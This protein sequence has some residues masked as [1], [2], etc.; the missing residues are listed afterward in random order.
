MRSGA[1]LTAESVLAGFGS[2]S[3]IIAAIAER[4]LNRKF[5]F[6]KQIQERTSYGDDS[7]R[8]L[9]GNLTYKAKGV[10]SAFRHAFRIV[11]A[12]WHPLIPLFSDG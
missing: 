1:A 9:Y 7:G 6:S 2:E 3:I 11:T 5:Q 4:K 12:S 8:V 10:T